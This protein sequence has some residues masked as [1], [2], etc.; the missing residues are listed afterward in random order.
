[1][2]DSTESS[3]KKQE[4]ARPRI[5]ENERLL[6][7][8]AFA[9][10][11]VIIAAISVIAS[12]FH[13]TT[14]DGCKS[15][16]LLNDRY[17]CLLGMANSTKNISIC[18][19][20]GGSYKNQ[21]VSDIA[22]ETSNAAACSLINSTSAYY[23]SC[24]TAVS[25]ELKNATYCSTLPAQDDSNCTYGVANLTGFSS[26]SICGDIPNASKSSGCADR[27]Y[28]NVAISHRDVAY[29]SYEPSAPNSSTLSYMIGAAS[30]ILGL[31][32]NYTILLHYLNTTPRSFCYYSMATLNYNQSLCSSTAGEISLLCNYNFNKVIVNTS[33]NLTNE[34]YIC[35]KVPS[36]AQ[37]ICRY[38]FLSYAAIKNRNYTDC[39]QISNLSYQYNCIAAI[40][41]KYHDNEYCAFISNSTARG[42]CNYD[43]SNNAT[44]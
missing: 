22:T 1:M 7:L 35:S 26:L 11:L 44:G 33:L 42:A 5:K 17:A 32:A 34:S 36:Y 37:N 38:S 14:L 24:V 27:Y 16:V 40:A 4:R 3:A 18:S 13:G 21:C 10:V 15:I 12:S 43:V 6:L 8:A 23:P 39:E 2:R 19:Y 25:L 20:L 9:A 31:S 30:G 41:I 29:C 28:Y